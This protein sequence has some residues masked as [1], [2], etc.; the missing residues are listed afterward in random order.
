M[1]AARA[2]L[3]QS[4]A[5]AGV[6]EAKAKLKVDA[7]LQAQNQERTESSNPFNNFTPNRSFRAEWRARWQLDLWGQLAD[8]RQLEKLNIESQRELLRGVSLSVT[9]EIVSA[10]LQAQLS[11]ELLNSVQQIQKLQEQ[12]LTDAEQ[13]HLLGR[14]PLSSLMTQ[15]SAVASSQRNL[16]N[17]EEQYR[18][19]CLE[20][21]RAMGKPHH[22]DFSAQLCWPEGQL[23][24]QPDLPAQVL[25]RRPDVRTAALRWRSCHYRLSMTRKSRWPS[26]RLTSQLGFISPKFNQLLNWDQLLWNLAGDLTAPLIDGGSLISQI[27]LRD[28]ESAEAL[29]DYGTVILDALLE[30]ERALSKINTLVHQLSNIED[31][32]RFSRL[33]EQTTASDYRLGLV[34]FS[35]FQRAKLAVIELNNEKLRSRFELWSQRLQL[36]LALAEPA[37]AEDLEKTNTTNIDR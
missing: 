21:A 1:E 37:T 9:A 29:A 8:E 12:L 31:D 32:L 26:L 28:A 16:Q 2:R 30:V 3:T 14:E 7:S 15:K 34:D 20:L 6:T 10:W 4:F 35:V 13:A 5:R 22:H 27:R 23:Q 17:A 19:Q 11:K 36:H 24:L 18:Q 25:E 33:R